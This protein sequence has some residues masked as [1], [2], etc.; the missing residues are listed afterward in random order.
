LNRRGLRLAAVFVFTPVLGLPPNRWSWLKRLI[1]LLV[2]AVAIVVVYRKV[3]PQRLWPVFARMNWA[4]F[5]AG[6]AMF[7]FVLIGAAG[8]WH[9]GLRLAHVAIGPRATW[10]VH[11]VGHFC[12]LIFF[13]A[14]GGDVVKSG[15]YARWNQKPFPEVMAAAPIDRLFGLVGALVVWAGL[16]LISGLRGALPDW[17]RLGLQSAQLVTLSYWALVIVLAVGLFLWLR[18]RLKRDSGPGRFV[19]TLSGGLGRLF[20]TPGEALAGIFWGGL[21]QIALCFVYALCLEAVGAEEFRWLDMFWTLSVI[22]L[23]AMM[24]S[25]AG[26]GLREGAAAVVLGLYG[27]PVETAVSAALLSLAVNIVWVAP[28]AWVLWQENAA[29]R[30]RAASVAQ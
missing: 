1:A 2:S 6:W 12:N 14:A 5:A 23:L 16:L 10:R 21:A 13:G 26:L 22:S 15:L 17:N 11:L 25:L 29:H 18:R 30:A 19:H 9:T 28:G 20:T 4:W 7:L 8:R 24:P 27:I 3:D